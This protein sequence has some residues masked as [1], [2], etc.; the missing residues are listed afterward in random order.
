MRQGAR[1]RTLEVERS[2]AAEWLTLNRPDRLNAFNAEMIGEL[3]DYFGGLLSEHAVRLVV[4]RGAGRGFCA[5]V[6]VKE[7][8]GLVGNGIAPDLEGQRRISEVIQKMRRCPQPILALLHG[9]ATGGG[10]ALALACDLRIAGES[11]RMNCAFIKLGLTSCDMGLSWHLPRLVGA[12]HA[13]ALMYTGRFIGAQRAAAIGLVNETVPDAELETAAAGYVADML[14]A[15][16]L[17]L[18]LTKD[19]LNRAAEAPNLAAAIAVEDRNQVLTLNGP[20]FREGLAALAERRRAV[21]GE[22]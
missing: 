4:L 14:A 20:D 10:F 6:D 21:W 16:P 11:A 13:A 12:A 9:A 5:G 8:S 15:A 17:G 3:D 18:R 1:Y 19:G 22:R 2:G 7:L